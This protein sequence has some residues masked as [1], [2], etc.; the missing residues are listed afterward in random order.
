[1]PELSEKLAALILGVGLTLFVGGWLWL[2]C[3]ASRDR[4]WWGLVVLIGQ[5]PVGS[6]LYWLTHP[7]RGLGPHLVLIAGV[8]VI[9]APFVYKE[10]AP[11]PKVAVVSQVNGERRGTLTGATDT[12]LVADLKTDLGRAVLQLANRPDVTDDALKLL[13]DFPE[14]REL[15]LNDTP[16]TD[17]GLAFLSTLPKL[18]ALRIAR[19][20]ATADG[21]AKHVLGNPRLKQIDVTGLG[22]PG[23]TLRE[24]KAADPTSRKHVN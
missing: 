6:S 15:D 10:V 4:W 21:V 22:V 1:M 13:A 23:K 8:V 14:L 12:D 16:V 5:V 20:K 18:E 24:W 11:P 19:T 2:T 9:A 3:R 17:A 7:R